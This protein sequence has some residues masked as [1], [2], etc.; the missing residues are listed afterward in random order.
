MLCVPP[1]LDTDARRSP[2]APCTHV[3][4]RGRVAIPGRPF[5]SGPVRP[6]LRAPPGGATG[7]GRR[8]RAIVI[9]NSGFVQLQ[10]GT[11]GTLSNEIPRKNAG[12]LVRDRGALKRFW[13]MVIWAT[14]A[15]PPTASE[16]ATLAETRSQ[17]NLF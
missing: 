3:R 14:P 17:R 15:S 10:G 2:L 11:S 12:S 13:R 9:E 5:P 7:A 6:D 4:K 8:T 1:D 16:S